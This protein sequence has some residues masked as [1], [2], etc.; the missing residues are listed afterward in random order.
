[1]SN[2]GLIPR[3]LIIDDTWFQRERLKSFFTERGYDIAGEAENGIE[4]VELFEKTKPDVVTMD[5]NMPFM[6]GIEAVRRIVGI[7]PKA[8]II[9]VSAMGNPSTIKEAID[10]GAYDF[11]VK[12]FDPNELSRKIKNGIADSFPDFFNQK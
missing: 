2:S 5:I 1:M 6:G 10:A 4:G 9:M 11:V 8:F 3:I 12:P 7:N